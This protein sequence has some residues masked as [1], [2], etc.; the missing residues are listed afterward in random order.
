[1]F[2]KWNF[3]W[4]HVENVSEYLIDQIGC[5]NIEIQHFSYFCKITKKI[6]SEIIQFWVHLWVVLEV[7][8]VL[9]RYTETVFRRN[10]RNTPKLHFGWITELNRNFGRTLFRMN[11][12]SLPIHQFFCCAK[13]QARGFRIFRKWAD[14]VSKDN[15]SNF[16]QKCCE[17]YLIRWR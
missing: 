17:E 10:Y 3:V 7:F 12:A 6:F 14:L 9:F 8:S 11:Y 1:M 2:L 5:T 13:N 16:R 15:F 4:K